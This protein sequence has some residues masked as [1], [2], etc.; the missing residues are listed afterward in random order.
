MDFEN[1]LA[2]IRRILEKLE[3]VLRE[4]NLPRKANKEQLLKNH[5]TL[6][7]LYNKIHE[8]MKCSTK[9]L[10]YINSISNNVNAAI[11]VVREKNA[12]TRQ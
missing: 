1:I 10:Q 12:K 8:S 7:S 6:V 3:D 9:Q 5:A 2:K 4:R 11:D